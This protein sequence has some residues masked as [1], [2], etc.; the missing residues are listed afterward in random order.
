MSYHQ[1]SND[2]YGKNMKILNVAV[3]DANYK[4][5][6]TEIINGKHKIV[7]VCPFYRKWK[8][9]IDRCYSPVL[10][11]KYPTYIDCYV[12]DEWLSFMNFKRWMEDQNWVGMHLDKDLLSGD[13]KIYS[14]ETCCFIDST[15]NNFITNKRANTDTMIGVSFADGA[16]T[17]FCGDPFS[18]V[19]SYL[20]RYKTEIEAHNAWKKRKH[21]L[22]LKL[23][24]LQS[25]DRVANKLRTMYI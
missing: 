25:D 15:L 8:S 16:F 10:L 4:I 11:N 14:P 7:W 6:K 13:L 18:G 1:R 24:D 21:E 9:M 3:N 19:Q 17:S 23:A 22:A 20:G 12:C 2:N 5:T